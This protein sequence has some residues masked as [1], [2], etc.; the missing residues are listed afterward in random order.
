[1]SYTYSGSPAASP[2][3]AT[4][5]Y[6]GD[7]NPSDPISTDE[8]CA[9]ALGANRQNPMLAA[10]FLAE[11]KAAQFAMRPSQVKRG[12]RT[13]S[14][15]DAAQA[16][17]VLA[18]QL[19]LNASIASTSIYAGGLSVSEKLGDNLDADLPQPVVTKHLHERQPAHRPWSQVDPSNPRDEL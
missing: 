19:R 8:E 6:L 1:M 15:G 11:T 13:T 9:F 7:T 12:D 4:H 14:Y 5:F 17:L 18:R 2:V 3:D 10:A 16:F